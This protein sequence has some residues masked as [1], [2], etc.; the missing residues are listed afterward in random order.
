MIRFFA[1]FMLLLVGMLWIEILPAVQQSVVMP[2]TAFLASAS[3][4]IILP[5]D[6]S[7]IAYDNINSKPQHWFWR[8][9]A[10]RL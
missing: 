3:T 10:T 2:F 7:A 8:C 5:F 4:Q 6:A 9:S 1:L